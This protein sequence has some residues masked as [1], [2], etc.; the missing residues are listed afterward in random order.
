MSDKQPEKPLRKAKLSDVSFVLASV[1]LAADETF[2]D[3]PD[4]AAAEKRRY[5]PAYLRSLIAANPAYV[6]ISENAD[7]IRTGFM[8]AV[9]DQGVLIS[10]WSYL[11][12]EHRKGTHAVRA[13]RSFLNFWNNG[14]FH[15]VAAFTRPQNVTART[16]MEH[17][18]YSE[19]T[20][21][22][23][24]MF[25]EDFYLFECPLNKIIAGY[26]PMP[27]TGRIRDL[28]LRLRAALS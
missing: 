11:L 27:S 20:L 6:M 5:T 13:K 19:K 4:F 8:I 23:K 16:L 22:E 12:P 2:G 7:G 17:C 25:G 26:D 15:K 28:K 1:A 3:N 14:R 21:L 10:C 9:P 18:G 24:H